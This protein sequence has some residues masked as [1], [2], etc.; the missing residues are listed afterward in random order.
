[1]FYLLF[2]YIIHWNTVGKGIY[3][4]KKK[5]NMLFL[6]QKIKKKKK[7]TYNTLNQVQKQ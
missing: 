3:Y 5:Y 4:L 7:D 2:T 1:M 6:S